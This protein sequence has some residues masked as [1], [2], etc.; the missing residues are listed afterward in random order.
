MPLNIAIRKVTN[1]G[2]EDVPEI[3]KAEIRAALSKMS[4]SKSPGEADI[5]EIVKE[6]LLRTWSYSSSLN[7][8]ISVQK[9]AEYRK[10]G[11][12]YDRFIT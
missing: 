11:K 3:T 4:N 12:R 6:H 9:N 8:L 1:V 2:S 7:F 5:V 10:N